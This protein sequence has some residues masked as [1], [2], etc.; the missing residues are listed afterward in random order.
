MDM[1]Q[2]PLWNGSWD[3]TSEK[4]PEVSG[5]PLRVLYLGTYTITRYLC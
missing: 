4:D 3:S 1:T 5:N 2:A